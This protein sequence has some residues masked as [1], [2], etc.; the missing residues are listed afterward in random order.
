MMEL[1]PSR[2]IV[3]SN[4][5]TDELAGEVISQILAINEYDKHMSQLNTYVREPIEMYISSNGGSA[6]AGF[7]I[8]AAMEMSETNIV[9]YGFGNVASMALG[10]FVCGDQRFAHRFTRFMYHSVL[11]GGEGTLK[12]HYDNFQ[13]SSIIQE[14][15]DSLFLE[16]TNITAEQMEDIYEKKSNF[17]FSGKKAVELGVADVVIGKPELIDEDDDILA[18]LR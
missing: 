7:A 14:M 8:I 1:A 3:I 17:F 2:K 11:Y 10:I 18:N 12:D 13:E 4:L 5:I 16:E 15:Y 9:T 6:S